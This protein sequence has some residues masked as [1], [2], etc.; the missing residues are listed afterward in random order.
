MPDGVPRRTVTVDAGG[1]REEWAA[2]ETGEPIVA[3][4][5]VSPP[6]GKRLDHKGIR[7]TLQGRV[8]TGGDKADFMNIVRDIALPGSLLQPT[9]FSVAFQSPGMEHESYQGAAVQVLYQLRIRVG[10]AMGARI[11]RK[12]PFWVSRYESAVEQPPGQPL[13]MEVGIEECLHL[14][15]EYTKNRYHLRDVVV[16]KI[17]FGLVRIA[18]KSM[19]VEIKRRET[20]GSGPAAMNETTLMGRFSIMDGAPAR[21][22]QIPIRLFLEPY[23]LTPSYANVNN[24]FAVSY[25]LN[26]VLVDEE[27]RR[28]FKQQEIFLYR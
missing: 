5:R 7:V 9:A 21:G 26:L 6:P 27:D 1:N 14:N 16:G 24:R 25:F 8:V 12:L 11:E 3:E 23:R 20:V 2:Y 4:V 17:H 10:L 22:E 13:R 19:E 15:F 28:Y 18:L